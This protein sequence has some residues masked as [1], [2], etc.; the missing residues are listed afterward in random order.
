M[1]A[2]I[3]LIISVIM[4]IYAT[5]KKDIGSLLFY[6]LVDGVLMIYFI[7]D[8]PSDTNL[9]PIVFAAAVIDLFCVILTS[10]R[11]SQ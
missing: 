9:M 1:A 3:F 4:A 11:K 6:L 8:C 10:L 5:Y 2:I 7:N